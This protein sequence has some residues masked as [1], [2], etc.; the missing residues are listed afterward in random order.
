MRHHRHRAARGGGAE[1]AEAGAAQQ[2]GQ[3][4]R[5]EAPAQA[6]RDGVADEQGADQGV[7][8]RC[9]GQILWE[10]D[11]ADGAGFAADRH[12]GLGVDGCLETGDVYLHIEF[13]VSGDGCI[14][15]L[16]VFCFSF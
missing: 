3:R 11:P 6:R 15:G 1:A 13:W 12:E 8:G 5:R 4:R 14:D 2:G 10:A 16:D 7:G 9:R